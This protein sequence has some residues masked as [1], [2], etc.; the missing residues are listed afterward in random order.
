MFGAAVKPRAAAAGR[1][2]EEEQALNRPTS[3]VLDCLQNGQRMRSDGDLAGEDGLATGP[4]G[5]L[6]G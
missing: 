4:R 3:C 1:F 2:G 6:I 5:R